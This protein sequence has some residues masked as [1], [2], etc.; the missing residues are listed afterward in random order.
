M[1]TDNGRALPVLIMVTG[2]RDG[3]YVFVGS[4]TVFYC[5]IVESSMYF[6]IL[7]S[8]STYGRQDPFPHVLLYYHN[9]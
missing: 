1:F 8:D 7:C 5:Q 2:E 4:L 9:I 3:S 6:Y